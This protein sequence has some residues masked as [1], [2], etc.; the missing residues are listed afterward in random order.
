MSVSVTSGWWYRLWHEVLARNWIASR[1]GPLEPGEA[2]FAPLLP[3]RPAACH[4]NV[5]HRADPGADP[6]AVA[7]IVR[8]KRERRGPLTG[9][10]PEMRGR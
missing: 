8:A 9:G 6:T 5:A 10:S 2:L 4:L 3:Y 1:G 7:Q